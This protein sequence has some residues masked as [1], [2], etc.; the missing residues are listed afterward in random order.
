[1]LKVGIIGAGSII[2]VHLDSYS[3]NPQVQIVAIADLNEKLAKEK[4]EA[5]KI[6]NYYSDYRKILENKEIDAV[7]IATPTFTHCQIVIE[8][9]KSGKHVLCEKPPALNVKEVELAV[10]TAQETGKLLMWEL[11]CRFMQQIQFL[12]K[13]IDSG[14]MG[15]II[16]AEACRINRYS[17]IGGWFANKEKA[18]GGTLID[19]TI[20]Q[21]DEI[22]YL[23]GYPKIK[24]VV[25]ISTDINN[26]LAGK[27]KGRNPG[28]KSAD[29]NTYERTIESMASGYVTFDNGASLYIKSSAITY[30]IPEGN[31]IDLIGSNG[32]AHLDNNNELT[33][34][35]NM[36][37]YMV[38]SKPNIYTRNTMFED[39]INHFVDCCLNNTKCI[40]EAWQGIE[41]MKII[42]GIYKSAETGKPVIYE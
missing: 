37:D 32:G 12:K 10:S 40:C 33:L 2:K 1:M 36:Y 29:T 20:H 21:I 34:L 8:A 25:G 39:A 6:P 13:H 11:P 26:D 5:Y 15:E 38:D 31:H 19:A 42:E 3:Q 7:S 24:T 16:H 30:S 17:A 9:L 18:G 4:A 23:M 35:S 14:N 22:M 27:L 41:L 28:W